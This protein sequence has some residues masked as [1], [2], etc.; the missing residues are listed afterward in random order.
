MADKDT[1]I[2]LGQFLKLQDYVS[3]GGEAKQLIHTF[4]ITVNEVSE[5]R[6]GKKLRNGDVVVVNGTKH[7]VEL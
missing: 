1:Y 3:S 7:T 2:T 6:R 5:N 4:E